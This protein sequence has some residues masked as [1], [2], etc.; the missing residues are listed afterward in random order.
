MG[1]PP[2]PNEP[3]SDTDT[4]SLKPTHTHFVSSCLGEPGETILIF[5][6]FYVAEA[7]RLP[8]ETLYSQRQPK[9]PQPPGTKIV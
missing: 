6:T 9:Q 3:G 1:I 4:G 5:H 7:A 8:Y 2:W